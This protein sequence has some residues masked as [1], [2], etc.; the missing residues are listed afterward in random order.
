MGIIFVDHHGLKSDTVVVHRSEVFLDGSSAK[1]GLT[2][3]TN[4]NL[5]L[6]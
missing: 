3:V 2:I 1:I 4:N 6:Y 5:G